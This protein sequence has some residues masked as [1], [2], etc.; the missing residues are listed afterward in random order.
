MAKR[1]KKKARIPAPKSPVT[2]KGPLPG[3]A[4]YDSFGYPEY[5]K[6]SK[7][8]SHKFFNMIAK[9]APPWM[10]DQSMYNTSIGT[11]N[12]I[13]SRQGKLPPEV[14]IRQQAAIE[15]SRQNA[16]RGLAQRAA[17]SGED[18]GSLQS[19]VL[20]AGA[21]QD[22]DRAQQDARFG[23]DMAADTRMREDLNLVIPYM[24]AMMGYTQ[25]KGRNSQ[26][27]PAPVSQPNTDWAQIGSNLLGSYIQGAAPKQGQ[28]NWNWGFGG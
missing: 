16:Q 9:N 11:I 2:G 20:S 13:L 8:K 18:P 10:A 19:A 4:G 5:A 22:Y 27:T 3:S 23:N 25:P 15:A 17:M 14:L 12:D 28:P 1:R 24:Q 7:A 26:I 21:D 6:G